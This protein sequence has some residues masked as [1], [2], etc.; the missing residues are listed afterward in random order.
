LLA[1]DNADEGPP[2]RILYP[3]HAKRE[4]NSRPLCD[5]EAASLEGLSL[6]GEKP[7][8]RGSFWVLSGVR[9]IV[10]VYVDVQYVAAVYDLYVDAVIVVHHVDVMIRVRETV[11]S[12]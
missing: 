11:I 6:Q 5:A 4:L 10:A 2:A 8:L 9:P 12:L 7:D 1:D 3:G